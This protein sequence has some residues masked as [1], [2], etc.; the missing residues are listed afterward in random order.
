LW[1]EKLRKVGFVLILTFGRSVLSE[2]DLFMLSGIFEVGFSLGKASCF[3]P[4]ESCFLT[5]RSHDEH[6]FMID[7]PH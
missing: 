6:S 5:I 4:W 7:H 2:T 1:V 3:P